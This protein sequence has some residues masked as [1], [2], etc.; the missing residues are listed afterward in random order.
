MNRTRLGQRGEEQ[1]AQYLQAQGYRLLARNWRKRE[2]E[3][4]I[5]AMDGDTLAFVEV[6]TRRTVRYGVAEESVDT[7]KQARLAQLAQRFIDE[8]PQLA[9]RECRFDVVVIDMTVLPP[10]IRL[11]RN[12]FYPPV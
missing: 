2:G 9:F 12:A 1:A 6:K 4:D 10:E 5:V 11:Y 8:H 3:L 7:R